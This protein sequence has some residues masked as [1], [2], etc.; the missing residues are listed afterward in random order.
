MNNFI[1]SLNV[2][3]PLFLIMSLGYF[4]KYINFFDSNTLK[5]LNNAVFKVFLP[6]LIF[7]NVYMSDISSQ[8]NPKLLAYGIICILIT[9]AILMIAVPLFEKDNRKRGVLIQAMFRSNFVIFGV[10]VSIALYG[11]DAAGIAAVLIVMIIPV[12]N[13]LAVITLEIFR[14]GKPDFKKVTMG[15]ITNPLIISSLIGLAI[16]FSGIRLPSAFEKTVSDLSKIATPLAFLV[17][18]GSI[19][20]GKA[21]GYTKQLI[22]GVTVKLILSP[23]IF[24]TIAVLLGFKNAELAILL[25]LFASPAAVSSFTMAQSMGGDD[26]LA[27]QLVALGTTICIVTMFLWIFI[28]KQLN[29]M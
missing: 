23:L 29:I 27:G 20:F 14:G 18:G 24:I 4:L 7:Y 1:L 13:F 12:Y 11:K 2:V 22:S 26:E 28:L 3:L 6:I 8:F 16:L 25:S 21:K 10:P 17:L 9:F 15:I 5:Q 19:N